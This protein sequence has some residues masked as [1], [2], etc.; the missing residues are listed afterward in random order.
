[1]IFA[2]LYE[3]NKPAMSWEQLLW[4]TLENAG[5]VIIDTEYHE[6][7]GPG[8][9]NLSCNQD[10]SPNLF[11]RFETETGY[12]KPTSKILMNMMYA[13]NP[14]LFTGHWVT[15]AKGL[16]NIGGIL[17][18]F[19]SMLCNQPRTIHLTELHSLIHHPGYPCAHE[20]DEDGLIMKRIEKPV[21]FELYHSGFNESPYDLDDCRT[22]QD[23]TNVVINEIIGT[24]LND[25][26]DLRKKQNALSSKIVKTYSKILIVY[27]KLQTPL[28]LHGPKN[29][30]PLIDIIFEYLG[31]IT[32]D[33]EFFS[34]A[35]WESHDEKKKIIFRMKPL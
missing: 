12:I 26:Y 6:W 33:S 19:V 28:Y 32:L 22:I 23:F 7:Y 25:M 34:S 24:E 29:T 5:L 13:R 18:S 21:E 2:T 16:D 1:L 35:Y 8:F 27:L 4:D 15:I 10:I 31:N 3:T 14:K 30:S 11:F 9:N 17:R 20:Y